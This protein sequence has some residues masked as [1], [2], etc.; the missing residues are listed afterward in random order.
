MTVKEARGI[1]EQD[2][3][4]LTDIEVQEIIDWLN[5]MADIAIESVEKKS[6]QLELSSVKTEI[7]AF[8][9]TK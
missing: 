1:L 9:N 7:P 2:A 8:I 4:G 6:N 5:M 3:D